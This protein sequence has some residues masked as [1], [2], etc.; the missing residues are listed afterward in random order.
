MRGKSKEKRRKRKGKRKGRRQ[1]RM[2]EGAIP[3]EG[4]ARDGSELDREVH[5]GGDVPGMP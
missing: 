4:R 3:H 2:K 1:G 5:D